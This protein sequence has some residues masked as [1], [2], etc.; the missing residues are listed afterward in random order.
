M[1]AIAPSVIDQYQLN[2]TD[3]KKFDKELGQEEFL[4]LMMAQLENQDP[5]KPMDNGEFLG[6]MARLLVR[7][8]L[9]PLQGM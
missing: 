8:N 1:T 3:E 7:S 9:I 5:M 4:E 6:Q 2:P